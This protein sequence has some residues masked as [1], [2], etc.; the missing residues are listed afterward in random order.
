MTTILI[1]S[2]KGGSGKSTLARTLAAAAAGDGFHVTTLD[3]DPQGTLAQWHRR[4]AQIEGIPAIEG[5]AVAIAHAAKIAT[6]SGL[7]FV[8]T[9][10][11][12]EAYPE[13]V[14]SLILAA[15]LVLIPSQPLPDDVESVK[16]AMK[17]V[18]GHKRKAVYV[19][20][21]VRTAVKE[22]EGAR[23]TLGRSGDVA[24]VALPDSVAVVR[25]MNSGYGPSEV[26]GRGSE[27]ANAL[28]SEI[29]RRVEL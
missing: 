26:S 17:I 3:T 10:T 27:E 15:D 21:R 28:W 9:P 8:D 20:N 5:K 14:N 24:A 1:L 18:V 2:P 25:A 29:R 11:A 16:T 7:L 19:L 23:M 22:V 4:R 13:A 6:S 12:I